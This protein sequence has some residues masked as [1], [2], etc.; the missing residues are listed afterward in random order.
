MKA[1]QIGARS[2]IAGL[3]LCEHADPTPS[4]GEILVRVIAAGLNF[5]DL[6]VLGGLYGNDLPEERVPLSDGVGIIEALGEGVTGFEIGD[7]VVAP[8]FVNWIDGHYSP[9][10]FA[11]DL[12]VTRNGWLAE[13]TILPARA[14]ITLPDSID[15]KSAATL[16]VVGGTV[17]HAMMAFGNAKPGDLVLAQGTGGVSIFTLLLAKAMGIDFAITSSSDEKLARAKEMGADF[18]VNYKKRPDW[19]AALLETTGGRGADIVVDTLGFPAMAETLA[20]TAVNGRIGTIGALSGSPQEHSSVSQG[21][22]IGKN[23]S[24]KGIASGS[25]DM[26]EQAINVIASKKIELLVESVFDFADA[27]AAFAHLESGAHM[28]KI[29]IQAD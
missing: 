7:R 14:A 24:I 26:L 17:W 5:R 12:G 1:W 21:A 29:L 20:A 23:A 15:D 16:S 2:G 8:H 28:G 3:Q 4:D 10:I 18:C 9:M 27:P 6:M 22:M 11:N 19:A 25:R 13:K